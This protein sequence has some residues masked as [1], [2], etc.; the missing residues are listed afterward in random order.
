[1]KR[2]SVHCT[3]CPFNQ[4]TWLYNYMLYPKSIC[5]YWTQVFPGSDLW[6]RMSVS[7]SLGPLCLWQCLELYWVTQAVILVY[8]DPI[9]HK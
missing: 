9:C 4:Q 8:N 1:M 3:V 5:F 7:D 2:P 6:V